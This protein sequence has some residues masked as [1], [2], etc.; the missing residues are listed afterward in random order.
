MQV[1]NISPKV[2]TMD[3]LRLKR[4]LLLAE[5]DWTQLIDCPLDETKKQEWA[6]YRQ[7][8]RDLPSVIDLTNPVL[9]VI[10][11]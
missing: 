10:P 4:N 3:E 1:I 7:E 5:C 2:M 11:Q 6:T 8:L 9:P